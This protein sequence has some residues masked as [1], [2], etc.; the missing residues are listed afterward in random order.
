MLGHHA[1]RLE[2]GHRV[3]YAAKDVRD[4]REDTVVFECDLRWGLFAAGTFDLVLTCDALLRMDDVPVGVV[5][6]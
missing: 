2:V 1:D 6:D 3:V 4:R 5:N